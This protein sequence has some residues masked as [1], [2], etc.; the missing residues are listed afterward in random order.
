M[1]GSFIEHTETGDEEV[2]FKKPLVLQI[3]PGMA[4][5]GESW[6]GQCVNIQ[7]EGRVS[8]GRPLGAEVPF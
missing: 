1:P 7:A 4:S 3:S 2:K 5:L 8:R 6:E